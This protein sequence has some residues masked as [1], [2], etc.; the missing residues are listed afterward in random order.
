MPAPR[1]S[2]HAAAAE[3]EIAAALERRRRMAAEK[4]AL[5]E[6]KALAEVRNAAV[7]VGDGRAAPHARR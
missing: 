3:R 4:I 7:E 6:A 1:P 5:E 2:A